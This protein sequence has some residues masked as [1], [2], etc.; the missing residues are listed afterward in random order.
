MEEE[1]EEEEEEEEEE[2]EEEEEMEEGEDPDSNPNGIPDHSRSFH[3]TAVTAAGTLIIF[4]GNIPNQSTVPLKTDTATSSN[5]MFEPFS[6]FLLCVYFIANSVSDLHPSL[7]AARSHT[8]HS[9]APSPPHIPP[10]I[11][12]FRGVVIFENTKWNCLCVLLIAL[13]TLSAMNETHRGAYC[14]PRCR[15]CLAL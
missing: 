12:Y 4:C 13:S 5:S 15:A 1:M 14:Q 6:S 8:L 2:K 3:K 10:G 11:N 9:L 7:S